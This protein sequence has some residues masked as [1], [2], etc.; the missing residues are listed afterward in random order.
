MSIMSSMSYAPS[1]V[2]VDTAVMRGTAFTVMP[3]VTGGAK[4]SIA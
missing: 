1:S 4:V 3:E 2:V